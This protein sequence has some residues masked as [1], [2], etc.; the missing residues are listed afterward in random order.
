MIAGVAVTAVG[1]D[2]VIAHPFGRTSTAYAGAVLGGPLLFLVGR[3]GFEYTVFARVSWD[4]PVGALVLAALT[5]VALHLSPLLTATAAAAVL[6]GVA[7]ADAA[8]T[9][10]R[11]AEPPPP[12]TPG[13]S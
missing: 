4:R 13:L 10:S 7:A 8:R 9:H 1:D 11:P 2:L 12:P 3:A 6:A 5:R